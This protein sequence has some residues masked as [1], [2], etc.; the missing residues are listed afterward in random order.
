MEVT[1]A[2]FNGE[3]RGRGQRC[4]R[5]FGGKKHQRGVRMACEELLRPWLH[6]SLHERCSK[7]VLDGG[8]DV[9]Q[10]GL[11][12]CGFLKGP[13]RFEVG[14]LQRIGAGG[15]SKSDFYTPESVK[16]RTNKKKEAMISFTPLHS[17]FYLAMCAPTNS[18]NTQPTP[19][20]NLHSVD[21]NSVNVPSFQLNLV[22]R[23][24]SDMF[25][26]FN[27]NDAF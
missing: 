3:R 7:A 10:A 21:A 13:F 8:V 25:V 2:K 12:V 4:R 24:V 6:L 23:N 27:K 11:R 26:F 9:R 20:I 14:S 15:H 22:P 17:Y 18:F 16:I 5:S 19:N 1:S